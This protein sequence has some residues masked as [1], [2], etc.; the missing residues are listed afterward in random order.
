MI[1][2]RRCT[3]MIRVWPGLGPTTDEVPQTSVPSSAVPSTSTFATIASWLALWTVTSTT[4]CVGGL[5]TFWNETDSMVGASSARTVHT[6]PSTSASARTTD[7][8]FQ[9]D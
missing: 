6:H 5:P 4:D 2:L 7:E 9:V 1:P 3:L 8:V